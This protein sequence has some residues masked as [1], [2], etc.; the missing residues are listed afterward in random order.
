MPQALGF[1]KVPPVIKMC[2]YFGVGG[3]AENNG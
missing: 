2:E 1:V 3:V